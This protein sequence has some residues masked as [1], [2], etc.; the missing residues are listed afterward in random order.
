MKCYFHLLLFAVTV[1]FE[2]IL[3]LNLTGWRAAKHWRKCEREHHTDK[4]Q[5]DKHL[6]CCGIRSCLLYIGRLF[7]I[8]YEQ[9]EEDVPTSGLEEGK[10]WGSTCLSHLVLCSGSMAQCKGFALLRHKP[11]CS[12]SLYA[13]PCEERRGVKAIVLW[14]KTQFPVSGCNFS[15]HVHRHV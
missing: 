10:G 7:R 14:Y 13:L 6:C 3:L 2:T 8:R 15:T 5:R 4:G 1:L 9:W 12:G 11:F